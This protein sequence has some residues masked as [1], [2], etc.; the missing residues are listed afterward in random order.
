[1]EWFPP[2]FALRNGLGLVFVE[3]T[4]GGKKPG[5]GCSGTSGSR[6]ASPRGGTFNYCCQGGNTVDAENWYEGWKKTKACAPPTILHPVKG[7]ACGRF[8]ADGF[9]SGCWKR[10]RNPE[11]KDHGDDEVSRLY[12][13]DVHTFE[14]AGDAKTRPAFRAYTAK[15]L[16]HSL[17]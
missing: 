8:G 2:T 7:D 11:F 14:K 16:Q 3:H 13:K 1:M 15:E 10:T 4:L 6:D 5:R 9:G 12:W 17:N